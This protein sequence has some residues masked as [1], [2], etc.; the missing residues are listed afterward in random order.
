MDCLIIIILIVVAMLFLNRIETFTSEYL[1]STSY[2]TYAPNALLEYDEDLY[3]I[4][5]AEDISQGLQYGY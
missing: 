3:D 2:P 1:Y 5:E 4:R